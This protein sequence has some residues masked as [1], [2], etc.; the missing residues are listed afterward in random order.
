MRIS[1]LFAAAGKYG[2]VAVEIA[3]AG[4]CGLGALILRKCVVVPVKEDTRAEL[5]ERGYT[6][7]EIK[8]AE[9]TATARMLDA[10]RAMTS[11]HDGR[12]LHGSEDAEFIDV[13]PNNI[14]PQANTP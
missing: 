14:G 12:H 7:E 9:G 3:F 5:V 1:K 2:T 11:N 8:E 13:P 4:I 10:V 6:L